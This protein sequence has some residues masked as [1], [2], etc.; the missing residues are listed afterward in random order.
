M[1]VLFLLTVILW[2][3]DVPMMTSFSLSAALTGEGG[4]VVELAG[5]VVGVA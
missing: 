2:S 1:A 5:R 4:V 3:T